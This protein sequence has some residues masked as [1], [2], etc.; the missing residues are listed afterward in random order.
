[1][2][3]MVWLLRANTAKPVSYV[4]EKEVSCDRCPYVTLGS[5]LCESGIRRLSWCRPIAASAR[6]ASGD[7]GTRL[8]DFGLERTRQTEPP[9]GYPQ[10]IHSAPTVPIFGMRERPHGLAAQPHRGGKTRLAA[11]DKGRRPIG[12]ARL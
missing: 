2:V 4:G 6:L 8:H 1:M 9:S 10:H 3:L 12:S 11:S 7:A 5:P